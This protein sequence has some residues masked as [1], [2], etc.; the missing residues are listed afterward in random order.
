MAAGGNTFDTGRF[1]S[2]E[3]SEIVLAD[4]LRRNRNKREDLVIT[5]KACHHYVDENNM[6][7]MEKSRVSAAYIT[8]DLEFSLNPQ[9]LDYFDLY[10]MHRDD[11]DAPVGKLMDRLERH[12][13]EG[14]IRAYG[15]SNLSLERLQEAQAYCERKGFQGIFFNSPGFSLATV[16]PLLSTDSLRG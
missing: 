8:E 2:G 15:V 3:K 5:S 7:H 10:M 9:Q 13:R 11:V 14:K 1:Y 6:H 4:W 16:A 12:R